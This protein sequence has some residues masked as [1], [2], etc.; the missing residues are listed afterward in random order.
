MTAA[1]HGAGGGGSSYYGHP[2]VT[3]GATQSGNYGEVGG[4]SSPLYVSETGEGGG[5][6]G[7]APGSAGED[8]YILLVGCGTQANPATVTSSTIISDPFSA[9]T[10]PTTLTDSGYVTGSSGQRILTGQASVSGQPS[11]QSMKW[12][13]E[14][15]NQTVKI[16]GVSLQWS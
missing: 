15:A 1:G 2:Q 6:Q 13:L 8:G 3:G 11:G 4:L 16:H 9:S 12:K 14:L 10:V 5:P 7:N